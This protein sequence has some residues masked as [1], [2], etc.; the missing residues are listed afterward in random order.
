VFEEDTGEH[1]DEVVQ[2]QQSYQVPD[3]E[4]KQWHLA[5]TCTQG[6]N[7]INTHVVMWRGNGPLF[8]SYNVSICFFIYIIY[9]K[10]SNFGTKLY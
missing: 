8:I 6:T 1:L 9:Y 7:H 5:H 10:K 4:V 3:G 2:P